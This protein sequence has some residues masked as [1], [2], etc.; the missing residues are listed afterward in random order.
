[1]QSTKK[2][3]RFI[4][5]TDY[6]SIPQDA[7]E[8]AKAAM[9]DCLGVTLAGSRELTGKLMIQFVKSLGGEPKGGVVGG[10]FYTSF[11]NAALAN[12]TIAHALDYDDMSQALGGHPSVVLFP[13]ILTLGKEYRLAGKQ[14]ICAYVLGFEVFS[15]ICKALSSKYFDD[16]GWHP[17]GPVG[18]LAAVTVAAKILKLNVEQTTRALG[19]A[20][21]MASGLRQNFGTMTKPFHAGNA[22][23]SGVVAALLARD[24]FT[25]SSQVL[26]GRCGFCHAFS[27]G[28]DYNLDTLTHNL[29][30][31]FGIVSQ[32]VRL[33]EYPC[34]G[35]AHAAIDAL[36]ELVKEHDIPPNLVT[37]IDCSVPFDPPRALIYDRP[38]TGSEGKFSMQYCLA[39]T[40]LDHKVSLDTFATE[41]VLRPKVQNLVSKI[42][43][44]RH[45]DEEGKPDWVSS[46]FGV[47]VRLNNG[48]E[49]SRMAYL[50]SERGG[51][52][53]MG[54]TNEEIVA[55]YR[56]C[57]GL[58]L[59]GQ[60]V[61]CTLDLMRKLE[62]KDITELTDIVVSP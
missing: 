11:P 57:A 37:R 58:V 10:G 20:G 42:T 61:D 29:G 16:L 1:M 5:E 18:T 44:H 9:L 23:M 36:L 41:Q 30:N 7:V 54:M 14:A 62:E 49:Y 3:A 52:C 31:P 46:K 27:G 19:L 59:K 4:V 28:K 2:L 12:G 25:A 21:S 51:L 32:G 47:T 6:E 33:K 34:C 48:K 60:D 53:S 45:P 17:T 55:K 40:L 13:V 26:E 38:K 56:D 8:I 22:C 35:G 43:M 50:Y 39:A 24:G 15:K